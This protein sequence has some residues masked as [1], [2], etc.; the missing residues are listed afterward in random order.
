MRRPL[1][2]RRQNSDLCWEKRE[3]SAAAAVST[4]TYPP[5]RMGYV[6]DSKGEIPPEAN[7]VVLQF[8]GL[9]QEEILRICLDWFKPVNLYRLRHLCGTRYEAFRDEEP[10]MPG[11]YKNYGKSFIEVWSEPFH[12]YTAIMDAFFGPVVPDLQ[13]ALLRFYGVILQLSKVYDWREAVLPMAIEVHT[14]I[15]TQQ[16][17]DPK[18]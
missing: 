8:A 13:L 1:R 10:R 12:N 2:L 15:V 3:R 7:R 16:P 4:V 14:H 9:P 11:T 18:N 17:L 6:D 5:P